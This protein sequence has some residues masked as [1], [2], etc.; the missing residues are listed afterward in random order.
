[1]GF[2]H[3]VDTKLVAIAAGRIGDD[4]AMFPERLPETTI[5]DQ[6]KMF[7]LN[8]LDEIGLDA[9]QTLYPEGTSW[10]Y[11]SVTP[12]KSFLIFF[13]PPATGVTN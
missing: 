8:K 7:L 4:F 10:E 2:P 13:V 3:W 1:M 5:S 6:A 11:T 9:L 12:D